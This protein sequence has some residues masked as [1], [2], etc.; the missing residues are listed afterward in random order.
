MKFFTTNKGHYW[1]GIKDNLEEKIVRQQILDCDVCL[2]ELD[3][4]DAESY[5]KKIALNGLLWR[6]FNP[7]Y[8]KWL[9]N[10]ALKSIQKDA[11]IA[12][13]WKEYIRLFIYQ[14]ERDKIRNELTNAKAHNMLYPGIDSLY[15]ILNQKRIRSIYLTKNIIE[16][17]EV[18]G[19]I[20]G[21]DEIY[22]E[23][24][25]KQAVIAKFVE[26]NQQFRKYF[27]KGSSSEDQQVLEVLEFYR[28]YGKIDSIISC[29]N[30]QNKKSVN[31][32]F[33]LN[34][35]NNY[36]PLVRLLKDPDKLKKE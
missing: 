9:F 23:V 36:L 24:F 18:F 27:I 10:T 19:G 12:E 8:A 30:A 11:K 3:D 16:I 31:E 2:S 29:Y 26:E 1:L 35:G 33:D 4:T 7:K 32:K 20:L 34:V 17:A 22:S 28:S 6:V 13:F 25:N 21:I 15:K 5:A 14:P